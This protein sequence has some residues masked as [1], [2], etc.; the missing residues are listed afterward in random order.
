[1]LRNSKIDQQAPLLHPGRCS[2]GFGHW[3]RPVD[4][5]ITQNSS[6]LL[7]CNTVLGDEQLYPAKIA[8]PPKILHTPTLTV[9][10]LALE[11]LLRKIGYYPVRHMHRSSCTQSNTHKSYAL[12]FL[13]PYNQPQIGWPTQLQLLVVSCFCCYKST[14]ILVEMVLDQQTPWH[15]NYDLYFFQSFFSPCK[16]IW[17]SVTI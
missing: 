4:E 15:E 8:S 5:K 1:M 16:R 7:T 10:F 14:L 17:R 9:G 6:K 11:Q 2:Q 3:I 12:P 13:L